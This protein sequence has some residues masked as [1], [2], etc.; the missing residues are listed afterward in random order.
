M[1]TVTLIGGVILVGRIPRSGR[2]AVTLAIGRA[3]LKD[4]RKRV[5]LSLGSCRV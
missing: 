5:I 1:S 3:P 2:G 4:P